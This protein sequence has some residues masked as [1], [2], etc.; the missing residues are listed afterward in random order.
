MGLEHNST[1][2]F[3]RVEAPFELELIGKQNNILKEINYF[4]II[5]SIFK[6]HALKKTLFYL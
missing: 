4:R 6:T 3:Q 1:L 5:V 2:L